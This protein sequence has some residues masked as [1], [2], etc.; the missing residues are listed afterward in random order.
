MSEIWKDI[1]GYEGMY[2]FSNLKNVK[3]LARFD[4]I[5]R[6]MKER[7]LKQSKDSNGYYRVDFHKNGKQKIYIHRLVAEYHFG[8]CPEGKECRHLDGIPGR[9]EP[10]NLKWG[11]RSENQ[12]DRNKHGTDM[13]TYLSKPVHCIETNKV[14]KSAREAV[15]QTGINI[16]S[17]CRT[18]RG[19]QKTA[20]GFSWEYIK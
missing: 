1:I 11:T 10:E 19:K 5:G 17:I 14:Y 18:C 9:D 15:R 6:W 7:I 16:A 8:P 13:S 4:S 12:L 2:Q 3:S 20:G